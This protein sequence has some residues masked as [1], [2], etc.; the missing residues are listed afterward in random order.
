V[1]L[2][3]LDGADKKKKNSSPPSAANTINDDLE[4]IKKLQTGLP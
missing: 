1:L 4:M 2:E 3:K